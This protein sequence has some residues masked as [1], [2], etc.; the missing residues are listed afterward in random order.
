MSLLFQR[1]DASHVCETCKAGHVV[2]QNAR[3]A[4]CVFM[5]TLPPVWTAVTWRCPGI[6]SGSVGRAVPGVDFGLQVS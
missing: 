1:Q 2:R 4:I 3:N 5:M 6:L